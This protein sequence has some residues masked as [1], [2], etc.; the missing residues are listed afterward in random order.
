MTDESVEPITTALDFLQNAFGNLVEIDRSDAYF[1]SRF[2]NAYEKLESV[3][4][5]ILSLLHIDAKGYESHSGCNHHEAIIK[6]FC[7]DAHENPLSHLLGVDSSRSCGSIMNGA[8]LR[9]M[10]HSLR[11]RRN[12]FSSAQR[13][14]SG[15]LTETLAPFPGC[16]TFC[17]CSRTFG[18][19]LAVLVICIH[20]SYSHTGS[21][22]LTALEIGCITRTC[23]RLVGDDCFCELHTKSLSKWLEAR[24]EDDRNKLITMLQ[25]KYFTCDLPIGDDSI[26]VKSCET[27]LLCTDQ[28]PEASKSQPDQHLVDSLRDLHESK[29]E[30]QEASKSGSS[31]HS[32]DKAFMPTVTVG[33]EAESSATSQETIDYKAQKLHYLVGFSKLWQARSRCIIS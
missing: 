25:K 15:A 3:L 7:H 24:V 32:L 21:R 22:H 4:Q 27:E 5:S 18:M 17:F 28:K 10:I 8:D 19:M 11:Q 16:S 20:K 6:A 13:E 31:I 33:G 14:E 26:D 2:I 1:G 12:R 29:K 23:V 30:K 9:D